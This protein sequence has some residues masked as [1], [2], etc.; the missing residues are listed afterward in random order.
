[1][2]IIHLCSLCTRA[3]FVNWSRYFYG[4]IKPRT[5]GPISCD[6]AHIELS[7]L[8]YVLHTL[9]G[10][11]E[12]KNLDRQD[13]VRTLPLSFLSYNTS[14]RRMAADEGG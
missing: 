4:Y 3:P 13:F 7:N 6:R 9:L 2:R 5:F 14:C 10:L 1:M 11:Q 8:K 12:T